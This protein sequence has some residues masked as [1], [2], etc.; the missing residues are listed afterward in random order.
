MPQKPTDIH[1]YEVLKPSYKLSP[2][3][4]APQPPPINK[5]QQNLHAGGDNSP[6]YRLMRQAPNPPSPKN[7]TNTNGTLNLHV[8]LDGVQFVINSRLTKENF[9]LPSFDKQFFSSDLEYDF[10]LE[11]E[12]LCTSKTNNQS[13]TNP[14]FH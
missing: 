4:A 3:R 9:V 14:F 7:I 6:S 10:N 11:R 2:S 13:L 1:Y 12:V 5:T 8:E